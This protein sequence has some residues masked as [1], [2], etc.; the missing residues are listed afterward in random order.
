MLD[1]APAMA[2][3]IDAMRPWREQAVL[4]GGWAHRLHR[5]HPDAVIPRYPPIVT[6]DADLAFD[7]DLRMEGSIATALRAAGFQ[8]ALRDRKSVV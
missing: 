3:L 5:L 8:E 4:V 1:D 2:R 6:R 7:A